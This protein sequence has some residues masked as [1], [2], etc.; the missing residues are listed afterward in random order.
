MLRRWATNFYHFALPF[1]AAT[2]DLNCKTIA[3]MHTRY[4]CNIFKGLP[5]LV[6]F[7]RFKFQCEVGLLSKLFRI[8]FTVTPQKSV[9]TVAVN[10]TQNQSLKKQT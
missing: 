3:C 6:N 10:I 2:I 8:A 5:G 4:V 1:L 7:G 9:T